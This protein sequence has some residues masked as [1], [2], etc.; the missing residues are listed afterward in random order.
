MT[1]RTFLPIFV[2]IAVCGCAS[3][4]DPAP[5]A[6]TLVWSDEFDTPGLPD[7]SKWSYDVGDH[8]WG[9]QELQNYLADNSETARVEDGQ[10]IIT[11]SLDASGAEKEYRSARMVT[12]NKGDWTYGRVE[13]RAQL[14]R[15]RGT[16]PAI[17]MLPTTNAYGGWPN[18]GEIDIM[19]HV[20]FDP[21]NVHGTVHTQSFNHMTGTQKGNAR[22]VP[23]ALDSLHIYAIEWYEDR[24]DFFIDDA[25]YFTFTNTGNGPADWPFDQPFHLVLNIAVGGAWGGQQGVDDSVFPQELRVD[26]VRIYGLAIS[27]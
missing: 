15:G 17:W 21:T 5:E 23:S 13:V 8:G 19:E 14:P 9:N 6:P 22:L 18:S 26:Y 24:I 2:L 20:G 7:A 10:L 16:W 27:E 11:A 4:S 12:K 3:E 1:P 25:P